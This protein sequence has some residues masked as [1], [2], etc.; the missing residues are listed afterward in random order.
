ME[1]RPISLIPGDERN[2]GSRTRARVVKN[3]LAPPFKEAEFDIVY[4][5]GICR[6]GNLLEL[7]VALEIVIESDD[8]LT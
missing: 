1:L 5:E 8:S 6:E 4:G 2:T 3:K 7:A